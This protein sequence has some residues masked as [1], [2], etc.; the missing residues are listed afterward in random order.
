MTV[1]KEALVDTDKKNE[2]ALKYGR[3]D[4]SGTETF[5]YESKPDKVEYETYFGGIHKIDGATEEDLE[6][7]K[8]TLKDASGTYLVTKHADGYYYP[9][10]NG[11][12]TVITDGSGII[13]IR[14]LDNDKKGKEENGSNCGAVFFRK[15]YLCKKTLRTA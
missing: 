3:E 6:G 7:V 14:G 12:G 5:P 4:N 15:D 13:K 10:P 8:F 11:S 2:S 1:N 9:D